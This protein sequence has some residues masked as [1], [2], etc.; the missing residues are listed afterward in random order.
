[1]VKAKVK[2]GVEA[3]YCSYSHTWQL[4]LDEKMCSGLA[5]VSSS[6]RKVVQRRHH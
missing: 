1:M 5:V 3:V 6:A 2:M 4:S